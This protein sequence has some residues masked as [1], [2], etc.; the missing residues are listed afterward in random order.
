[1]M[2]VEKL[3]NKL[4]EFWVVDGVK[5][6]L[7]TTDNARDLADL[8]SRQQAVCDT[9]KFREEVERKMRINDKTVDHELLYS[10]SCILTSALQRLED[11][12]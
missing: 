11:K 12:P 8:I 6:I 7:L 9:A 10:S 3:K 1:M 5:S 2:D 4:T